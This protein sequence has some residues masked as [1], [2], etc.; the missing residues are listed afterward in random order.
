MKPPG[1]RPSVKGV[2][3]TPAAPTGEPKPMAREPVPPP[4]PRATTFAELQETKLLVNG[5]V[6]DARAAA[7]SG[8]CDAVR[9]L[10]ARIQ[11]LDATAYRERLV[12]DAA[13]VRCVE[14][15]RAP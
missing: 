15:G 14:A 10:V 5:L 2:A 11:P 8:N 12:G 13:I 7:R 6:K 4:P 1:A 9:A 3:A